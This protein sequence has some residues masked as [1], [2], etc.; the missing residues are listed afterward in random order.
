ML[1]PSSPWVRTPERIGIPDRIIHRIEDHQN[2]DSPFEQA[3][4]PDIHLYKSPPASLRV[5]FPCTS[6]ARHALNRQTHVLNFKPVERCKLRASFLADDQLGDPYG[7]EH[8]ERLYGRTAL[9][10]HASGIR[11]GRQRGRA[12]GYPERRL[13]GACRRAIDV[14]HERQCGPDDPL[15]FAA[16]RRRAGQLACRPLGL[17]RLL[18]ATRSNARL[19]PPDGNRHYLFPRSVWAGPPGTG[20]GVTGGWPS[21]RF[22]PAD[23]WL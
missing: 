16:P 7:F 4:S 23:A 14:T 11:V 19:V 13:A 8:R 18:S 9:T 3:T 15:R 2:A 10:S 1:S 21:R 12:H 22:L 17:G 6:K 20:Q 5:V